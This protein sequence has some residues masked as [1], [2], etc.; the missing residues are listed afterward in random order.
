MAKLCNESSPIVDDIVL[1]R[2][3]ES[4]IFKRRGGGRCEKKKFINLDVSSLM[5]CWVCIRDDCDFRFNHFLSSCEINVMEMNERPIKQIQKS[6]LFPSKR[7]DCSKQYRNDFACDA[8]AYYF[9]QN[10]V[11]PNQIVSQVPANQMIIQSMISRDIAT[12]SNN[13]HTDPL[14]H[15][16]ILCYFFFSFF[17]RMRMMFSCKTL[18]VL[19]RKSR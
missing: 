13:N 11:R 5:T 19:L 3:H 15:K 17:A 2:H 14:C 7:V 16:G 4:K 8:A 9:H 6:R 18:N 12:C 10:V 1:S